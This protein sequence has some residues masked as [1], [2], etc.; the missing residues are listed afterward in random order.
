MRVYRLDPK[1]GKKQY[2]KL[3]DGCFVL[4]DPRH[5]NEKHHVRNQ[6]LVRAEQEMIDLLRLGYSVRVGT[7]TAPS[8][9]SRNLFVDGQPLDSAE[10]ETVSYFMVFWMKLVELAKSVINCCRL[11]KY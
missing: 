3:Q 6:V 11:K 9:V 2:P 1:S 4:G 10:Y 5:G 7:D 8:L